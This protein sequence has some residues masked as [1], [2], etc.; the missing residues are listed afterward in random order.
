[1]LY[2]ALFGMVFGLLG[3]IPVAGPISALILTRGIEARFRAAVYISVGGA[4]AEAIY[5]FLAFWGFSTFLVEYPLVTPISRG[6]GA[7]MLG[8]LGVVMVRGR[9]TGD[10][11]SESVRM[12]DTPLKSFVLGFWV[13]IINPSLLPTW[14]G[15]VTTLYSTESVKFDN[16]QA[17]PFAA[18]ALIGI[19]AWYFLMLWV[20]R[21]YRG[22]F[23]NTTLKR[24]IRIV[25]V[26]LCGM[27][28]W[29]AWR[30]VAYFVS[31][32]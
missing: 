16:H 23:S 25:G 12:R 30:F 22:R 11:V 1:M 28:L 6:L 9:D 21:R 13:C 26:G 7:L 24:F 4:I 10:T 19:V 31:K 32:S 15:V 8:V 29:F 20:I 5:A 18:G 14:A 27:A 17:L 3:S 2:A